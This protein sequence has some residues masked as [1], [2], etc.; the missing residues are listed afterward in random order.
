MNTDVCKRFV[1]IKSAMQFYQRYSGDKCTQSS[2]RLYE[3][4]LKKV[5]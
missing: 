1:N 5:N 3:R 2:E 4:N